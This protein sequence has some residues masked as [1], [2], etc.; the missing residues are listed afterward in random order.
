MTRKQ[1]QLPNTRRSGR[2]KRARARR[3][4]QRVK[5][6]FLP[7]VHNDFRPHAVRRYALIA[8]VF[9]LTMLQFGYNTV[10]TGNIL[11]RAS[12]ISAVKLL[13]ATNNE[14]IKEGLAPLSTNDQLNEAAHLKASD[15]FN[16]Q[17]W[18]HDAPD[19]TPPWHWLGVVG[20]QYAHAGENLAKNYYSADSAV[21][22]WMHSSTHRANVL[23]GE[24]DDVGFAV[25]EG[26]LEGQEAVVIVAM[27]GRQKADDEVVLAA[28]EY[29]TPGHISQ[30]P[31]ARLGVAVQSMSPVTLGS[32]VLLTV[33]A[34]VASYAHSRRHHLPKSLRRSWYRHHGAYKTLGLV[35][36]VIIIISLY[37]GG[38]I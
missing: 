15:M 18:S 14:R 30:S 25:V 6:A 9:G 28:S 1:K 21:A 37:G 7:H 38:Q 4:R 12:D 31:V 2:T 8:V 27:Y 34:F 10:T 3:A 13:E 11:G 26:D 17:Y 32:V 23:S 22:A 36:L 16:R 29:T 20:Y 35:S 5:L 19:G 24:Y 33:L